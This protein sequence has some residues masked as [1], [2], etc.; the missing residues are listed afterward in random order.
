LGAGWP[1]PIYPASA[2][3]CYTLGGTVTGTGGHGWGAGTAVDSSGFVQSLTAVDPSGTTYQF[4]GGFGVRACQNCLFGWGLLA[5][6]ITD[7][8]GNQISLKNS[9]VNASTVV[10]GPNAYVDTMGRQLL[11]W[12]G[13]GNNGDTIGIAGLGSIILHW[14]TATATF[15][16]SGYAAPPASGGTCTM[17]PGGTPP[18]QIPFLTEIDL[19]NGTKYTFTPD[20]TYGRIG[21]INFPGGGYVRYVWGLNPSSA[22]SLV[23]TPPGAPSNDFCDI[24]VDTPAI[25]D[26]YVSYDGTTEVLHQQFHYAPT[27]W[28]AAVTGY[29]NYWWTSK[30]T[31]VTTTDMLTGLS[32]VVQYTYAPKDADMGSN[33]I[34]RWGPLLAVPVEQAV[35]YQDGVGH[36]LKTV[37]KTWLDPFA[38][39]GEQTILDNGKGTTRLYCYS[40]QE[41][42]TDIYEYG[43]QSEGA[44]PGDPSCVSS[45]GLATSALGP[46][47]RH[48]ATVY[49][50][51]PGATPTTHIVNAPDSVIVYDGSGNQSKQTTFTY[52]ANSV[53]SSGA[54]TGLVTPP[55]LRGNVST[56]SRW[57]NTGGSS[58]T[59]SYLYFDTGQVLSTTD[60]CGNATCSDM[61][62]SSHTTTYSYA[63]V[64]SSCSGAAPPSGATNAYLTKITDMLGHTQNFCYG[65]DDGQ[66]RGSTDQNSQ[67]TTYKYNDSLA[68]LTETD[69]PDGGK[70]T[71]AYNDAP[72]NA[73]TPSPSV[74]TTRAMNSTTNVTSL[75]AF[76]GLGHTV[77]SVLTSDPDCASGDRTDTTYDGLGR[78]F[79]VSN[80]YC[81]AGEATSGL[82]TFTYDALGRT[83]QVTHPDNSTVLTTYSGRAT[84]VQDEG[85]GTQRVT[86]ISQTD[87]LGHLSSLCEVASGP[88]VV[89]PGNST[90]SLIGSAGSPVAC[91]QDIAG[92]GFL[93]THQYDTLSNLLQ[94]NQ[95]G[96]APRTFTYDSLSRLLTASNPE[97]GA[98][99][100]TYDANGNLSTKTGPKQN[101][102]G[103]ATVTTTYQYDALNRL[104]QKSYSDGTTAVGYGYDT[105]QPN[106]GCGTSVNGV[107][108]LT[109]SSVPG[110]S[111]CLLYDVMGRITDKDL[112]TPQNQ[113]HYLD[114]TY[115]LLGNPTYESSGYAFSGVYYTYNTAAR[116]TSA[117]SGYSDS[118]NPANVFSAA[119]YNAFG[120]LTSDT[121]GDNET[122]TYT[123]VPNLTRLQ[124]Y[125][126]TLNTTTL[127]NF[128][129]GTFAP[130]GDILS[131][132]DT[133]NGNWTYS[134]DQFNRLTGSN[135]NSGQSVFSYAYDRFGNRW[136]QNGSN[137]F[138]A[139]FTGNNPGNPQNNNR[140]DGY[141]Y[142]AAGNMTSDGNNVY[143]YDAEN[144][145][146]QVNLPGTGGALVATYVYD[147]DGRRVQKTSTVGNG[148]DPAGT[149][150]YFYDLAGRL[151][152]KFTS[153]GNIFHQGNIYAG[154]RHLAT[155]GGGTIFSHSDWL[156]TERARTGFINSTW[157]TCETIASLPFGDGQ[158]TT[159]MPGFGFPYGCNPASPL[160]FTGKER[161][162][163]SGLDNFGARFDSSSLGRFM[164]P[165]WSDDPD[166]VP[167]ANLGNPQTLNLYAYTGNNPINLTDDDGHD[168]VPLPAGNCG[169]WCRL[170]FIFF[171]DPHTTRPAPD[172]HDPIGPVIANTAG[173]LVNMAD[174]AACALS[175]SCTSARQEPYYAPNTPEQAKAM[176]QGD[177]A[178]LFIPGL[179]VDAIAA[180]LARGVKPIAEGKELQAI[181]DQLYRAADTVPGGTAG[182]VRAERTG[183]SVGG[184]IHG[185]KAAQ[186]ARQLAKLI[187][188]GKFSGNDLALAKAIVQDLMNSLT[189][190]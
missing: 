88:F 146:T 64:Y 114:A 116:L 161:D 76:D 86:R 136:Q 36:T 21:R 121:L 61:T 78:V 172:S 175:S 69:F 143:T 63:D 124:S 184:K 39:I 138:I 59:T 154:G 54:A 115:D 20:S 160:H 46:L 13:I 29:Y 82:T 92:T 14:G 43:F 189:G 90:A 103:T 2:S 72:F 107:G 52:D 131:A 3:F 97:S 15:P 16:E 132:S 126:A 67:T 186:R 19:P 112:R 125:T 83:T 153:P 190:K 174:R 99:S 133:A 96:I 50:N 169:F 28:T 12:T 122:E 142:D 147:A 1:D 106:F 53:Q 159:P 80:P 176:R 167:Y 60:A 51:F 178:L 149:W 180:D 9:Q 38:M 40:S 75:V 128:N 123:Y 165:D 34:G 145:I 5:Q 188:R 164:S 10:Y 173:G 151:V 187:A 166:P 94:V 30:S 93:T 148:S 62:G 25:T 130:N 168:D 26:R 182:A 139:T 134:Y 156:G 163:E 113:L 11:S 8:N 162:A 66:L 95:T 100:Y 141:S 98:I 152:Q 27:Q 79:S 44:Y 4:P 56:V 177:L 17:T 47:R 137:S 18:R 35:L 65:Y 135:K 155:V 57:L 74:T 81:I 119:H 102:T 24:V 170:K 181:I 55:G 70:T 150:I 120:A 68:R 157:N 185:I 140:M 105:A 85:N 45:N 73:S 84:Q 22:V 33:D 37:N 101:Q 108:R 58:P 48:T 42:V 23:T 171:G 32:T 7:R 144:R 118:Q 31:T 109:A 158:T 87:G 71:I 41:Q 110:W 179:D 127:Y 183:I 91:G 49:H 117:T 77:R 89:P 6:T 111:F 129:I 104:I